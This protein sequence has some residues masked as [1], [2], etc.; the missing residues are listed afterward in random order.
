M[1]FLWKNETFMW[2]FKQLK[3]AMCVF[4]FSS[5]WKTWKMYFEIQTHTVANS[6]LGSDVFKHE[7]CEKRESNNIPNLV[8]L[9]H[10]IVCR[11]CILTYR[12]SQY[13]LL[14]YRRRTTAAASTLRHHHGLYRCIFITIN[15]EFKIWSELIYPLHRFMFDWIDCQLCECNVDIVRE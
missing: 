8:S 15:S 2:I 14:V 7:F 4:V 1:S 12:M 13:K 10:C 3:T 6:L 9:S 11:M 5:R